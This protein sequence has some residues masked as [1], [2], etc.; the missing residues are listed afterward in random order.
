MKILVAGAGGFIGGH[1]VK[2]LIEL[3]HDVYAVDIKRRENWYQY[4]NEANNFVETDMRLKEHCDTLVCGMDR[5]YNLACNMGGMGFIQNNHALCL[6]SVLIQTHLLQACKNHGVKDI[7]YSSSACVYPLEAQSEI[8]SEEA[9]ALAE[10]DAYP[11]NPEDGYGWE[12]LFSEIITQYFEQDFEINPRICRYH[13]VY[14][15]CF[16]KET[17]VLTDNGWKFFENLKEDDEICSLSDKGEIIYQK[18]VAFQ[19]Y[20]YMGDMYKV[21]AQGVDQLITPD[22]KSF[23]STKTTKQGKTIWNDFKLHKTSDLKWDSAR[24]RFTSY[25]EWNDGDSEPLYI[26]PEVKKTDGRRLYKEKSVSMEDWFEF[27]GWY[28]SEGSMFK[29]SSNYTVC[30]TQDNKVN[31]KNR[32]KI[33]KLLKRMDF[34]FSENKDETQILISNKQLYNALEKEEIGIGSHN[35]NI[36][37]WMLHY[38]SKFLNIL[39]NSLMLGDGDSDGGRYSTVSKKLSDNFIELGFKLGKDISCSIDGSGC[40]RISISDR[41]FNETRRYSRSIEQYNDF[42]YDVTL[43]EHH[44][45][46]IKR[47]GKISWSGNCGTWHGGREKVPAAICRKVIKAKLIGHN[48]IEI[49]GDGE[50]TRSF[51][52]IDDCIEGMERIWESGYTKPLNLGSSRMVS[53]NKLVDIVEDIAGVKLE[54]SYK[55]DAPQGVR[56]RNSDNTLIKEVLGW[57]PSIS[58]EDGLKQT[59]DW[60]YNQIING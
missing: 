39:Y 14:G 24:M 48:Q 29:T 12:K 52:F 58:L 17:E 40:F 30:I 21:N 2:H 32:D 4:F 38:E 47:N 9:Q 60:I 42:V 55:L 43:P 25:G 28:I 35:K 41:K 53:I 54:R 45:L 37:Q 15:P 33:K 51:C 34:H 11:A 3:G 16:D 27:I 6:E 36:P 19:K 50:Q 44:V 26:F 22:H 46:L 23:V 56:G 57:E 59:Y 13:N 20:K 1:L 7:L 31:P 18:F 49:W 8:K 10:S 5:V